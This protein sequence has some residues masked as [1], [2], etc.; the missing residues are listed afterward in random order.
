MQAE[1]PTIHLRDLSTG[2]VAVIK[3]WPPYPQEFEDLDYALRSDGWL[4]EYS[5]KP[6][7]RCFIAERLGEPVAFTILS[8]TGK[9]E[10]EFRIA[11]R[12]DM[13]GYGLGGAITT[14]TLAR[15]FAEMGLSRIHLIVRKNNPR[16]IRLY[17]RLGFFERGEC[18]KNINGKQAH[19]LVMDLFKDTYSMR[20]SEA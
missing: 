10:A 20:G 7:T 12:A 11:L 14:M 19:F 16:A 9:N 8:K 2:D 4:H 1:T 18:T 5:G 17:L 3:T 15:G 6:D 13:T